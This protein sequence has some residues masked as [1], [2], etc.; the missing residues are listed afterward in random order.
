MEVVTVAVV[1][2][3]VV[4]LVVAAVILVV[5][6]PVA[7]GSRRP[8]FFPQKGNPPSCARSLYAGAVR[9]WA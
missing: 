1:I 7:I 6:E 2:V 8:Y 9:G 4:I 3:V 5:A